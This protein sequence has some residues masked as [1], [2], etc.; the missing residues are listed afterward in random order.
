MTRDAVSRWSL[1]T[2]VTPTSAV[3][4]STACSSVPAR[5]VTVASTRRTASKR[6]CTRAASS[7][8]RRST[9]AWPRL[10]RRSSR[11][12]MP[13][14]SAAAWSVHAASS[15]TLRVEISG[16]SGRTT[17]SA[18][19]PVTGNRKNAG[20]QVT[21]ATIQSG[22]AAKTVRI[23]IQ[24]LCRSSVPTSWVSSSI[25]SSTSP[26][27]CSV[28]AESGWCMAASSRSARSR[29]SA[30]STVPAHRVRATVSSSAAPI[31]QTA[32]TATRR[33]VAS[34]ASRPATSEPSDVP[35]AATAHATS[36]QTATGVRRRRQSTVRAGAGGSRRADVTVRSG[37]RVVDIGVDGTARHGQ[38]SPALCDLTTWSPVWA[39]Q[40]PEVGGCVGCSWWGCCWL[41]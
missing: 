22:P 37:P 36:A 19:S 8:H 18:A 21:P 33:S 4:A 7:V 14:S 20:H 13:S 29:P 6:A 38:S 9:W 16:S 12:A 5:R 32:S 39:S 34:S 30:R 11:P 2:R 41:R 27:A 26:T 31:T 23:A 35:T 10:A 25:R 40:S 24:P 28:S 1:T 3:P 15:T 17:A